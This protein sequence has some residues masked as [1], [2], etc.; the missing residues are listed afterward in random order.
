MDM[1]HVR[2]LVQRYERGERDH[3]L[4]ASLDQAAW[5]CFHDPWEGRAPA[6]P[7]LGDLQRGHIPMPWPPD[8][9]VSIS[10]STINLCMSERFQDQFQRK[11]RPFLVE[12]ACSVQ[13]WAS[14]RVSLQIEGRGGHD[15][16][17]RIMYPIRCTQDD[18]PKVVEL[19]RQ[20]NEA[21]PSAAAR[22][23]NAQKIAFHDG[24]I[25]P[26][27]AVVVLESKAGLE[28][29]SKGISLEYFSALIE[30]VQE[31]LRKFTQASTERLGF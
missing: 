25:S 29:R 11:D 2:A 30:D 3:E 13:P 15:L 16:L 7:Q 28:P 19:V 6:P 12:Y 23:A 21:H 4:L 8:E 5:E 24:D 10:A 18:M 20:W 22:L 27:T 1:E 14:R 31:I 9:A 26:R 17:F